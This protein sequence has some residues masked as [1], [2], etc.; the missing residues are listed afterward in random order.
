MAPLAPL[1]FGVGAIM[2]A[3]VPWLRG[4]QKSE[5]GGKA[6]RCGRVACTAP[7][8]APARC[9]TSPATGRTWWVGHGHT[10]CGAVL[11]GGLLGFC[12]QEFDFEWERPSGVH[13]VTG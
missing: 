12:F 6:V 8:L 1:Y 3:F 10:Q 9:P 5:A 2:E 7:P 13:D 11:N 4:K